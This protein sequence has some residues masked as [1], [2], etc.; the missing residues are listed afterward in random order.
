MLFTISCNIEV[1][2][3]DKVLCDLGANINFMPL[4]ISKKFGLEDPKHTPITLL[5]V[6]LSVK[7]S[8]RILFDILVKVDKFIVPVDFVV[9]DYNMDAEL[10]IILGQPFLATCRALG[11]VDI[12]ELRFRVGEDEVKFSVGN[13]M[14]PLV[15][16]RVV[17]VVY[18]MG[19]LVDGPW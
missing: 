8:M 7:K 19:A 11:F 5:M 17:S 2:K 3:L 14:K 13:P 9:L 1:Y 12:G 6:E 15:D 18:F 4:I 10:P 16:C